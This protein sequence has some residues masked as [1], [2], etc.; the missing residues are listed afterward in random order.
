MLDCKSGSSVDEDMVEVISNSKQ[1]LRFPQVDEGVDL[2][3][4]T[5][6]LVEMRTDGLCLLEYRARHPLIEHGADILGEVSMVRVPEEPGDKM[7]F[8]QFVGVVNL[9]QAFGCPY[10]DLPADIR[11]GN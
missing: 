9:D 11:M 10:P 7:L 3:Q 8:D 4:G 2:Q 6:Q 1:P 5:E